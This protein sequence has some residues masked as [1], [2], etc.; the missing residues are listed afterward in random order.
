MATCARRGAALFIG[1]ELDL[2]DS[3]TPLAI[4]LDVMRGLWRDGDRDGA[5]K[6]ARI[7]APYLHARRGVSRDGAAPE[8]D[9]RTLSDA[10]LARALAESRDGD[11]APS[12][13]AVEPC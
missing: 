1:K 9:P 4:L 6:L 2:S 7:A 8:P 11:H 13:T 5:V 3:I 10:D 12:S